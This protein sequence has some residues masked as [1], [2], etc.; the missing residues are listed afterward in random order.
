M[1][2]LRRAKFVL[3]IRILNL[4]PFTRF[5]AVKRFL[6]R[7]AG[8]AC[9]RNVRIAGKIYV[10]HPNVTFGAN[11]WVGHNAQLFASP[12]AAIIVGNNV[13]IANN[14]VM[15]TGT[16]AVGPSAHRAGLGSTLPI[17][18]GDGT[19]IGFNVSVL[20]GVRIAPGCVVA[21]GAVVHRSSQPNMLLAGVPARPVKCLEE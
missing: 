20:G 11:V 1:K 14:C 5:Y 6:L 18:I 9:G 16:H 8:I 15:V 3:L 7:S 2:L 19:W 21:A 17:E 13:D 10:N 12:S 4:I